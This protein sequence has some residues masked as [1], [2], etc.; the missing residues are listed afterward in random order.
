M[1][2]L[3][4]PTAA[5]AVSANGRALTDLAEEILRER[6]QEPMHFKEL[7]LEGASSRRQIFR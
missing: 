7:A 3:S 6:N 2:K 4:S 5:E 1:T